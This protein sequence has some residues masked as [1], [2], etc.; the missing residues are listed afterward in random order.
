MDELLERAAGEG[1]PAISLS[2][3]RDSPAVAFYERN[4]FDHVREDASA[5]VMRRPLG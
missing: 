3:E 2:V 5:V 4:G 1:H